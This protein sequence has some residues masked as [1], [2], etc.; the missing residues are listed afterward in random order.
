M[1][2]TG[3]ISNPSPWSFWVREVEFTGFARSLSVNFCTLPVAVVGN[4]PNTTDFGRIDIRGDSALNCR[5]DDGAHR[6]FSGSDGFGVVLAGRA[7]GLDQL[8][9]LS[10]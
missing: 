4:G 6:W 2:M 5:F 1:S 9:A 10:P 3:R 7:V 8:S